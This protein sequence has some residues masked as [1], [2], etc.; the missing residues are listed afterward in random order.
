MLQQQFYQMEDLWLCEVV[1]FKTN[2][3]EEFMDKFVITMAVK[4]VQNF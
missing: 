2:Q 1:T 4:V 3:D